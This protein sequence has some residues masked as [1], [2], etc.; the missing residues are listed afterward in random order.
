M[1]AQLKPVRGK[2][3]VCKE[4]NAVSRGLCRKD[5][6]DANELMR[7]KAVTEQQLIDRGLML[8]KKKMGRP[9]KSRR[10]KLT[11][12]LAKQVTVAVGS[13]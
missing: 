7:R 9:R 11:S 1:V 13:S 8:P 5:L 2:C 12:V 6:D 3:I 4:N 10:R